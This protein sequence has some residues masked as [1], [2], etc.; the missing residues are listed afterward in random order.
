MRISLSLLRE[1]IETIFS[2]DQIVCTLNKIG[3]E[4]ENITYQKDLYD[5]ICVAFIKDAQ[6]HPD[7]KKLQVCSVSDGEH[8]YN[9]VCGASNARSGISTSS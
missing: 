1:H 8:D 6:K 4:V 7:A 9:I 5:G 3:I 2:V